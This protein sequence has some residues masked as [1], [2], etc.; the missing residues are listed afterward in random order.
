MTA[1]TAAVIYRKMSS[2]F[3]FRTSTT[4]M[5]ANQ[6]A[7]YTDLIG[8]CGRF[9]YSLSN[10]LDRP[11]IC[12]LGRA[13]E[14]GRRLERVNASSDRSSR[15]LDRPV[16]PTI[17]A[18]KRPVSF[19]GMITRSRRRS[20]LSDRTFEELLQLPTIDLVL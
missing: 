9:D 2:I 13:D 1:A 20:S 4:K 6:L 8:R 15:K 11:V 10:R 12:S 5:V 19:A 3:S 14:S 17:A 7:G 18:C 16:G